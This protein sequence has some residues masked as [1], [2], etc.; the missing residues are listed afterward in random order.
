MKLTIN[1]SDECSVC[2]TR[3]RRTVGAFHLVAHGEGPFR[4]F[5]LSETPVAIGPGSSL[6][7][8]ADYAQGNR[9]FTV[10]A[11]HRSAAEDVHVLAVVAGYINAPVV[12]ICRLPTGQFVEM[13][14]QRE[15]ED[16]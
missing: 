4:G 11:K 8:R 14:L 13:V 10:T 12:F 6:V 9:M 1:L 7:V 2:G 5:R 16:G 15:K 3:E